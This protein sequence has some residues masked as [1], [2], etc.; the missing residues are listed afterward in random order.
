MLMMATG[1][2]LKTEEEGGGSPESILGVD[3]HAFALATAHVKRQLAGDGK[4]VADLALSRS[5]LAEDLGD[6]A[7]FYSS[8]KESIQLL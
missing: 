8:C 6:R 7:G 5:K 2:Q 4:G 3:V 1:A